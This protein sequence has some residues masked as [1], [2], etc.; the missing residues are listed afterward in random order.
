MGK[1][2]DTK[3]KLIRAA[4]DLFAEDGLHR[5]SFQQIGAEL[6]ISQAALYKHFED[7]D[8]LV[9]ACARTAHACKAERISSATSQIEGLS[10][11]LFVFVRANFE[12][13]EL[14]RNEATILSA[15]AYLAVSNE[16]IGAFVR[17]T[18]KDRESEIVRLFKEGARKGE[19]PLTRFEKKARIFDSLLQGELTK[20][21][22]V[23]HDLTFYQRANLVWLSFKSH[24]NN[25][26]Q[27]EKL[28]TLQERA[29][30]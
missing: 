2:N 17:D 5:V 29:D 10:E 9:L 1:S 7:K 19:W 27:T 22:L 13:Q 20:A 8:D 23:A 3:A 16:L 30:R 15:L 28:T 24:L 14:Y 6:G 26:V 18:Q 4:I 12:W 21:L 11:K 25:I